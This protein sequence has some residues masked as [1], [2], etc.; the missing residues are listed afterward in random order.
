VRSGYIAFEDHGIIK[1]GVIHFIRLTPDMCKNITEVIE[2]AK[3]MKRV[4]EDTGLVIIG[5]D[6]EETFRKRLTE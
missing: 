2:N 3:K 5:G 4:R 6:P 1:D